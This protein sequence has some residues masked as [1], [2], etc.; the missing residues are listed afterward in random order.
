MIPPPAEF[1]GKFS[2]FFAL[3]VE[4]NLPSASR[5]QAFDQLL[6]RHLSDIDPIYV[7]RYV[8]GQ[9][10]GTTCRT[11]DGSR[12]L[13]TDNAPVWW[14]HAFLLSEETLPVDA[15]T[16]F[17]GL[18][19][20]FHNVARFQTLNQAGFHAAHILTAKNRDI[21]WQSWSRDEVARRMMV[22][23]HPC[24]V[25][26]VAKQEWA[27]NGGRQDIIEWVVDAYRSRYGETMARFLADCDPDA[28]LGRPAGDP[29]YSYGAGTT[30][31]DAIQTKRPLIRRDLVGRG[32]SL[33]IS[34]DGA[35]YR[36]PHNDLVAWARKHT[37]ALETVSWLDRGI[38]SWPRSS[39]AMREFLR[40]FRLPE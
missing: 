11:A 10:R 5:V 37:T 9:E 30:S 32:V 34:V 6:R 17:S 7:T 33:E 36:L 27:R 31:G 25:F 26:L 38:Y 18:P 3:C 40:A 16:L 20:H 19:C 8:R 13:P 35:R 4:P 28:F 15:E 21:D 24:N 29:A 14:L 1:D 39:A 12:I 23:L 2:E 22:N